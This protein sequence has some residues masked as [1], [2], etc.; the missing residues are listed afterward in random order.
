MSFSDCET[1]PEELFY[2]FYINYFKYII[3]Y[4]YIYV[5]VCIYIWQCLGLWVLIGT[6]GIQCPDQGSNWAPCIGNAE[7]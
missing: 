7:S 2:I 1:M 6:C 4:I 3:I 5:Y